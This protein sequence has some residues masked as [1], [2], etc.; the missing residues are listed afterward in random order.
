[1]VGMANTKAPKTAELK[2]IGNGFHGLSFR[3]VLITFVAAE[4]RFFITSA[5]AGG[6]RGRRKGISETMRATRM[7]TALARPLPGEENAV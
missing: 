5:K 6:E 1:M 2:S 7:G 3:A 4:A